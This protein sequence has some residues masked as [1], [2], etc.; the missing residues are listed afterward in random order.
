VLRSRV[1]SREKYSVKPSMMLRSSHERRR[2]R[3][4]GGGV[5]QLVDRGAV[6]IGGVLADAQDAFVAVVGTTD[7]RAGPL[8][9][10]GAALGH[11]DPLHL[12]EH[13]L[14]RLVVELADARQAR[15]AVR[16]QDGVGERR[17]VAGTGAERHL[18]LVAVDPIGRGARGVGERGH[19]RD[20][21]AV[22]VDDRVAGAGGQGHGLGRRRGGDRAGAGAAQ[23]GQGRVH[24]RHQAAGARDALVGGERGAAAHLRRRGGIGGARG[25]RRDDGLHAIAGQQLLDAALLAGGR[26]VRR[27]IAEQRPRGGVALGDV[28]QLVA[29]H[30]ARRGVADR[31]VRSRQVHVAADRDAAGAG[32]GGDRVGAVV[33]VDPRVVG[34]AERRCQP[35]PRL[36]GQGRRSRT[37]VRQQ[38]PARHRGLR[39]GAGRARP[40]L[41][42]DRRARS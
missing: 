2:E 22:A 7:Q 37:R 11:R 19:A 10:V 39:P 24:R 23:R 32:R 6:R 27:A 38:R 8:D 35:R 4:V 28:S 29:E 40:Q 14:P 31:R 9:E 33:D 25:R 18:D 26:V 12:V 34:P 1:S 5:D 20:V 21:T 3:R 42:A 30:A 17:A 15:R 16:D 41:R 36:G 13:G